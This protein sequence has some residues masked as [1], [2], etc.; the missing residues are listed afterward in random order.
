M[1][2]FLAF[3]LAS[4]TRVLIPIYLAQP[5]PG[6]FG[7]VWTSELAMH[8]SS[9][10]SVFIA[11]CSPPD[12]SVCITNLAADEEL[13]PGE[14]E[15]QLPERYPKPQDGIPGAV[16]YFGALTPEDPGLVAFQ[17]RVA[18]TSRSAISA[19]TEIPVV[20]ENEFRTATTNLPNVPNDSPF[21][22]L[23]R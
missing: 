14:T 4:Y 20:R 5:I 2:L 10:Q 18:D 16:V 9:T 7:S 22:L 21:R 1:P 11:W 17:L 19:G 8:N 15:T 12:H 6:A 13:E 3:A 23:L